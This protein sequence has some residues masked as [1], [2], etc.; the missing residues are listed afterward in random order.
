MGINAL[1]LDQRVQAAMAAYNDGLYRQ[2]ADSPRHL[3]ILGEEMKRYFEEETEI[4]YGWVAD[5]KSPDFLPDPQVLFRSEVRFPGFDLSWARD[6]NTSVRG[7]GLSQLIQEAVLGGTILHETGFVVPA[8]S[9]LMKAPLVFPLA[10]KY[11]EGILFNNV[12]V[13]TCSWY[14]TL[15]N[16]APLGGAH[17]IYTGNTVSMVMV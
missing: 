11:T 9:Y 1:V 2:E 12:I 8:G 10:D 17:G 15:A 5:S 4:T 14:L 3:E 6:L 13:P 16:P 7:V